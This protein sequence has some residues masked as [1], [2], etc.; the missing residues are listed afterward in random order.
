M[1]CL[2]SPYLIFV[3]QELFSI[4][5]NLWMFFKNS[6]ACVLLEETCQCLQLRATGMFS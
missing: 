1:S 3:L 5:I 6:S 2:V 4:S